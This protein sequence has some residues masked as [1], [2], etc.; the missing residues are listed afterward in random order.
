MRRGRAADEVAGVP[1]LELL[2]ERVGAAR[3]LVAR[4]GADPRR[5]GEVREA[6][7]RRA[8][9]SRPTAPPLRS[10]HRHRD[11]LVG[12]A[13]DRRGDQ[14]AAAGLGGDDLRCPHD[15]VDSSCGHLAAAPT[16]AGA[17][18]RRDGRRRAGRRDSTNARCASS[19]VQR[20]IARGARDRV[21]AGR[22]LGAQ[23]IAELRERGEVA[24]RAIV[25]AGRARAAARL[26]DLHR[27]V[28]R[29]LRDRDAVD[30]QERQ[31]A[32]RRARSRRR[33]RA[34]ARSAARR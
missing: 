28:A 1:G 4:V 8:R 24:A 19:A 16:V 13:V 27:D 2:L 34:G 21:A 14:R 30:R 15:L 23:P 12:A 17:D 18:R 31:L 6:A 5:A 20:G 9:R 10:I 22:G 25:A 7:R 3:E 32:S 29:R 33:P 11:D 26:D